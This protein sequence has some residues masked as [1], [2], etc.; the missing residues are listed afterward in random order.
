MMSTEQTYEAGEFR[1][2]MERSQ[3]R[4]RDAI[5]RQGRLMGLH[6]AR[7]RIDEEID[8][9]LKEWGRQVDNE[10]AE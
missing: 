7:R 10:E 5:I 8:A 3:T 9:L 1:Q 2:R 6:A 4:E